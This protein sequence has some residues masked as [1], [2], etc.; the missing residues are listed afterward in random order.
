MQC[1]EHTLNPKDSQA[2]YEE[3]EVK[4]Q[5]FFIR[6]YVGKLQYPWDICVPDEHAFG[7][8]VDFSKK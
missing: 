7:D 4:F 8:F 1:C 3:Q 5:V 2:S 6:R